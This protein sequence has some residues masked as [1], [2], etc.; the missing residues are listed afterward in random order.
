MHHLCIV[1]RHLG[2]KA[3]LAV[4]KNAAH[5]PQLEQPTE[6]NAL[7]KAFLLP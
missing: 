3:Q 1:R 4:V 2:A 7:V 6:F 5:V